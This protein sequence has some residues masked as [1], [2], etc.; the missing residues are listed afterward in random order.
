MGRRNPGS[1]PDFCHQA[2]IQEIFKKELI[3]GFRRQ[4]E[5]FQRS[6]DEWRG[7]GRPRLGWVRTGE[8]GGTL[9]RETKMKRGVYGY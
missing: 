2:L 1:Y 7:W 4:Q 3:A 5:P 6:V 9:A 8:E